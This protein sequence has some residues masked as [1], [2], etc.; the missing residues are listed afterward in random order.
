MKSPFKKENIKA[1]IVKGVTSAYK[2]RKNL[3]TFIKINQKIEEIISAH[4]GNIGIF[5]VSYKFLKKL[6][7]TKLGNWKLDSIIKRYNRS[8]FKEGR[9][10][11]NA[12]MIKTFKQ[13]SKRNGAV[14]L[15][16]LGGK[17][18][19]GEDF[20]GKDMETV[21][22][23]GFPFLPKNAFIQTKISYFN[24]K[25]QGKGN[26]YAYIEPAIRKSNQA[27]G[28]PIRKE[29]D[30]GAIIFLDYRYSEVLLKSFLSKWLNDEDIL[31]I[32]ENIPGVLEKD[33]KSFWNS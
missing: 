33:L 31:A 4:T 3:E 6:N 10:I 17:N 5:C 27:A 1:I 20:P 18:S 19:E 14:L 11:N 28:R 25:F 12:K 15:G 16:V 13:H 32:V 24:E 8:I 9:N 2:Q 26:F 29:D 22:I 21:I 23:V 30:K 7:S